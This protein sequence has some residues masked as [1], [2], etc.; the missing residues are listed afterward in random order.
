MSKSNPDSYILIIRGE[1]Y[2]VVLKEKEGLINQ[3]VDTDLEIKERWYTINNRKIPEV[4]ILWHVMGITQE[5]ASG[6]D[7]RE[8]ILLLKDYLHGEKTLGSMKNHEDISVVNAKN[9]YDTAVSCI[10]A[11]QPDYESSCEASVRFACQIIRAKLKS[12]G[13]NFEDYETLIELTEKLDDAEFEDIAEIIPWI[14]KSPEESD[15]DFK[16]TLEDA[17]NAVRS[18]VALFAKLFE[19]KGERKDRGFLNISS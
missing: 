8:Q 13:K 10:F 18:S 7:T 6:L 11:D 1:P 5:T 15:V 4:N 16:I 9:D 2:E 17:V 3:T 12:T 19:K 14:Q